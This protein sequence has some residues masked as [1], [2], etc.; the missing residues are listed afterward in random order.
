MQQIERLAFAIAWH[1]IND[2]NSLFLH[3]GQTLW[4]IEPTDITWRTATS[5]DAVLVLSKVLTANP[6]RISIKKTLAMPQF[7]VT[8]ATG[9]IQ[10]QGNDRYNGKI[11]MVTVR[12]DCNSSG[13]VLTESDHPL[14]CY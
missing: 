9:V 12:R 5:Y 13:F 7:S 8:G 11:T 2:I 10:F 3:Q 14:V 6:T 1:P 4:K